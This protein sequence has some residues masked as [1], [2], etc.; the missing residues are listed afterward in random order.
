MIKFI[1]IFVASAFA[2]SVSSA[3]ISCE[4]NNMAEHSMSKVDTA[5][6]DENLSEN[7]A[8]QTS[9]KSQTVSTDE[10]NAGASPQELARVEEV[11]SVEKN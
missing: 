4:F 3:A 5:Q 10:I 9:A 1:I 8:G 11:S 6:M 7:D 2:F